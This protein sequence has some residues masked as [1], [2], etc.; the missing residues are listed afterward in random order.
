MEYKKNIDYKRNIK[1]TCKRSSDKISY[2]S[3]GK[4]HDVE[5]EGDIALGIGAAL[6]LIA[7]FVAGFFMVK[8]F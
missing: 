1:D 8:R 4:N 5:M 7:G 2:R 3:N 6:S